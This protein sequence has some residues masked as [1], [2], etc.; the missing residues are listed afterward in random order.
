M[1]D[2]KYK[3][4]FYERKNK[5]TGN[6][7]YQTL[8]MADVDGKTVTYRSSFQRSKDEARSEVNR[9]IGLIK[10]SKTGK[11]VSVK[12]S[13]GTRKVQ[14]T[15]SKE[16]QSILSTG[17]KITPPE[18]Y[19][20]TSYKDGRKVTQIRS[21]TG[22]RKGPRTTTIAAN[23]LSPDYDPFTDETRKSLLSKRMIR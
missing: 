23:M 20:D 5:L 3:F 16:V 1:A 7:E 11:P 4:K 9:A 8:M 15:P 22:V 17:G 21:Q 19:A 14:M 13:Y 10:A 12:Q 6:K 2:T 18:T